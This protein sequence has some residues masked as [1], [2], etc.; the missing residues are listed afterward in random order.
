MPASD[1]SGLYQSA[2]KQYG[3]DPALLQAVTTVES[4]GNPNAVSPQGARGPMQFMP[5][6]AQSMG[7]TDPT[8]PK[9]A[10]PAAAKLLIANA[11]QFGGPEGAIL[12]YHGGTDQKNWGPKT[13]AYLAKVTQT[14]QNLKNGSS[15]ASPS[16]SQPSQ[17]AFSVA[18]GAG[19]GGT[20]TAATASPIA[21]SDP[22]PFSV[23]FGS[24]GSSKP[25]TIPAKQAAKA[26][27]SAASKPFT[28]TDELTAHLP[29]A[30]DTISGGLAALDTGANM[31]TG[32]QGPSFGDAYQSNMQQLNQQQAAYEGANPVLSDVA[33]GLS[34]FA[35]GKPINALVNGAKMALPAL[36]KEGAKSGA[37]LGALFGAG[38]PT[39]DN[40]LSGRALNTVG[41]GLLGAGIGGA[42]PLVAAPVAAAGRLVGKGI[43]KLIPSADTVAA[44]KAQAIIHNFAGG[45]VDVGN[46]T[47]LV[48]GSQPTLAESSANPGVASLYRA[49]RDL[50]PNSP[51]IARESENQAARTAAFENVSGS[52]E[53]IEDLVTARKAQGDKAREQVFAPKDIAGAEDHPDLVAAMHQVDTAP[54]TKT[55]DDVLAGSSGNRPAV[56][57]A[58]ADA[59]AMLQRDNGDAITDPKT[60]YDSARKGINDLI[61]G[62]DLTKSYGATAA[63]QLL[64]VR[65]SLDDAIEAKAPGFKDYLSQYEE[66]SGPI[67]ALKFLQGQNVTDAKG[68]LTLF[69]VQGA[70]KKLEQQQSAPGVK[71]G[72]SV[73]DA[74]R[75][76]LESIRDD[77][78]RAQNTSYGKAIG[79]NTIQNAMAQ[80]RLG[81]VQHVNPTTSTIAGTGLGYLFGGPQGAEA[82]AAAGNA[83]GNAAS[84]MFS[85]SRA[86]PE[87]VQNHL[88]QQL[89]NPSRYANPVQPSVTPSLNDLLNSSKLRTGAGIA[90]RLAV[91]HQLG[92]RN[93][94][95]AP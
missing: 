2:G 26:P 41:G 16:P 49:V 36:I 78:L 12:A 15:M 63:S 71:Q 5:A 48:T 11:K 90:N 94:A 47:Q 57:S 19:D 64:K 54:V 75:G 89:L 40:S 77:L 44:N 91:M 79:S 72:K 13:Q 14:Y 20:K 32:K 83:L 87:M 65:D 59:K 53:D 37:T 4:D 80:K 68:N 67:D 55:I 25:A 66:N 86:T 35:G 69:K 51:L 43:N 31:L 17:D 56:K 95:S 73:T 24:S 39:A 74:Q 52:P 62:K 28:F 34:I 81:L 46:T 92:S 58:M 38:T 6:T 18:F 42:T 70:L 33:Q 8:D 76:V 84:K 30:K 85:Y 22:D 9:Q 3:I 60:L 45:P 29:F 50:N 82:G 1:Y 27:Q 21:S 23:A 7:V 10:I 61:S 93:K 88:E